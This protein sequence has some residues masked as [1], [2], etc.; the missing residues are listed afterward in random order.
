[1][2]PFSRAKIPVY[3]S[4][5]HTMTTDLKF[6]SNKNKEIDFTPG[7]TAAEKKYLLRQPRITHPSFLSEVFAGAAIAAIILGVI[8]G[9]TV[10]IILLSEPEKAEARI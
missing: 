10:S 1:M 5:H 2:H 6:P 7:F 4:H 8:V 3:Q 9:I